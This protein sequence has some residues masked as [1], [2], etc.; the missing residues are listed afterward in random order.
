MFASNGACSRSRP[1]IWR[2]A[3]GGMRRGAYQAASSMLWKWIPVSM[4]TAPRPCGKKDLRP[5]GGRTANEFRLLDLQH[6]RDA[7]Q[8]QAWPDTM[9]GARLVA[10]SRTRRGEP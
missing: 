8:P 6:N 5:T 7:V 4:L 9:A 1:N 3:A 2:A 10:A